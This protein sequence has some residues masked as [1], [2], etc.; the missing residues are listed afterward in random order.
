MDRRRFFGRP[1]DSPQLQEKN[2]L[3]T[4]RVE[5]RVAVIEYLLGQRDK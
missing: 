3:E 2:A 5:E 4:K 1:G